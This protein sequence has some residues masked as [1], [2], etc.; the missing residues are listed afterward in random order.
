MKIAGQTLESSQAQAH[1]SENALEDGRSPGNLE[2]LVIDVFTVV[3]TAKRRADQQVADMETYIG[4]AL[5][6]AMQRALVFILSGL[7][8]SGAVAAKVSTVN[9]TKSDVLRK[10]RDSEMSSKTSSVPSET[11]PSK[12]ETDKV[13]K[14]YR[15]ELEDNKATLSDKSARISTLES[16]IAEAEELI[17]S[18]TQK[19]T[20]L[21]D[22]LDKT[23]RDFARSIEK[24]DRESRALKDNSEAK[25]V[26]LQALEAK[27]K[28]TQ[29]EKNALEAQ[30]TD[31]Q[32]RITARDGEITELRQRQT[33]DTTSIAGLE[34]T[35]LSHKNQNIKLEG[36]L[37]ALDRELQQRIRDH[38][39]VQA[40]YK[41]NEARVSEVHA[42]QIASLSL[43]LSNATS[44]RS[45]LE[46]Q[47]NEHKSLSDRTIQEHKQAFADLTEKSAADIAALK[48]AITE[49]M[50]KAETYIADLKRGNAS[51]IAERDAK[52]SELATT[53]D[54]HNAAIQ[55]QVLEHASALAA[56]AE[57]LE[58]TKTLHNS[59][60]ADL[61]ESHSAE[62]EYMKKAVTDARSDLKN[63]KVELESITKSLQ[64]AQE[65]C[66]TLTSE[67]DQLSSDKSALEEA[68]KD[69]EIKYSSVVEQLSSK[70]K[71]L[72]ETASELES[73]KAAKETMSQEHA[74]AVA[75]LERK[76]AE[77]LSSIQ[78]LTEQHDDVKKA[79]ETTKD[80]YAKTSSSL[81]TTETQLKTAESEATR[82]SAELLK[83]EQYIAKTNVTAVETAKQAE[84]VR[85]QL[86]ATDEKLRSTTEEKDKLYK[87]IE[88]ITHNLTQSQFSLSE[89]EKKTQT[90]KLALENQ[91]HTVQ[92]ALLQKESQLDNSQKEVES[93]ATERSKVLSSHNK[94]ASELDTIKAILDEKLTKLEALE[95]E[96]TSV[97]ESHAKALA[98]AAVRH[99][100]LQSSSENKAKDQQAAI[101]KL[102]AEKSQM[103]EDHAKEIEQL[104]SRQSSE[105]TSL[106]STRRVPRLEAPPSISDLDE[107]LDAM[108]KGDRR[109]SY[110]DQRAPSS[111]IALKTRDSESA[112]STPQ[113]ESITRSGTILNGILRR[114]STKKVLSSR[115]SQQN[116]RGTSIEERDV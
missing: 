108:E 101:S 48:K 95:V 31:L 10:K 42:E 63:T 87:R 84:E 106:R 12:G 50:S 7:A 104:R 105:S 34:E 56:K 33:A 57:E 96:H 67:K 97:K 113:K 66:T 37:E 39:N 69:L 88:Q 81:A 1:V 68:N 110:I 27:H 4:Q 46:S 36:R 21:E 32:S 5:S 55:K 2:N 109:A 98:D 115:A 78:S 76:N 38:A 107:V 90:H 29:A 86:T 93:A 77:A 85:S 22:V 51:A 61:E 24:Q 13:V 94:L 41:E 83:M 9:S 79:L 64:A 16:Q 100:E 52:T 74:A 62:L 72:S 35:V 15:K 49:D 99:Q 73:I 43:Q 23:N 75:A 17:A 20:T 59:E 102:L 3:Y 44:A 11:V 80:D 116:L 6:P 92:S 30:V 54:T 19:I 71:K 47:Y 103:T 25:S 18:S 40:K 114:S 82:M 111:P 45:A 53:I 58:N 70:E 89:L 65:K 14:Q 112:S 26:Q 8:V 28:E 91:L 60:I